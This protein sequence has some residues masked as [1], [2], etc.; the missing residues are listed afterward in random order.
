MRTTRLGI[1]RLATP[2]ES[3]LDK[4]PSARWRRVSLHCSL[5]WADPWCCWA[6]SF[7]C[8]VSSF[9]ILYH[10]MSTSSLLNLWTAA[11]HHFN[12]LTSVCSF[13]FLTSCGS[14]LCAFSQLSQPNSLPRSISQDYAAVLNRNWPWITGS[15][16]QGGEWHG[17]ENY[18]NL[19]PLNYE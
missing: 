7:L 3:L 13:T 18:R 6:G 12:N 19:P 15:S 1:N 9:R 17:P 14:S 2:S 8:F 4:Q 10:F 16:T 11:C 5:E